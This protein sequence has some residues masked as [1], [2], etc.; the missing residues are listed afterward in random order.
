MNDFAIY[1]FCSHFFIMFLKKKKY[2][3]FYIS[4]RTLQM[5]KNVFDFDSNIKHKFVTLKNQL[6][7]RDNLKRL[8]FF[9]NFLFIIFQILNILNANT[10][11]SQYLLSFVSIMKY[12]QIT[13][14][15]NKI[16]AVVDVINRFILSRCEIDHFVINYENN[17]IT[18]KFY[19]EF[20]R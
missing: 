4:L 12:C 3:I 7:V 9:S 16:Y 17:M 15:R 13:N 8:H 6:I 10:I 19:I 2:F 20:A 11:R 5:L 1:D 18:K 14:L